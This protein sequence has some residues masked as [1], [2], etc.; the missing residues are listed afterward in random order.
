MDTDSSSWGTP[1]ID[2]NG[3]LDERLLVLVEFLEVPGCW[4]HG[5][6][7][8]GEL[9]GADVEVARRIFCVDELGTFVP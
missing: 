8:A 3:M 9:M 7:N 5:V 6:S 2:P 4:Y 1:V